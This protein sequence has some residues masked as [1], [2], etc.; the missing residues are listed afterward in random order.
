MYTQPFLSVQIRKHGDW[1]SA[2]GFSERGSDF[3]AGLARPVA[4]VLSA[5]VRRGLGASAS[6]GERE[7]DGAA[8]WGGVHRDRR[9]KK[10]V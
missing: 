9:T 8:L 7:A 10:T 5:V 1:G 2:F 6:R 3:R 4:A